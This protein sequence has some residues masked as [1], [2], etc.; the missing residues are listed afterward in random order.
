[1]SSKLL[2]KQVAGIT[3]AVISAGYVWNKFDKTLSLGSNKRGSKY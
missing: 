3:L 1:M 2:F